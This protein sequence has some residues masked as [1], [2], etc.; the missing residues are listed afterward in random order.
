MMAAWT[1][2]IGPVQ[3]PRLDGRCQARYYVDH[4]KLARGQEVQTQ[5]HRRYALSGH[6]RTA[7]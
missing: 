4:L 6:V 2:A 7:S 1:L 5:R 3:Q